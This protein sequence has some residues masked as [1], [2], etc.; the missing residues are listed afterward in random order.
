M[1]IDEKGKITPLTEKSEKSIIDGNKATE[2]TNKTK[3]EQKSWVEK[4]GS[5]NLYLYF[6]FALFW[7]TKF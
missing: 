3:Q 6:L 7:D 4:I 1:D 5:K 2:K